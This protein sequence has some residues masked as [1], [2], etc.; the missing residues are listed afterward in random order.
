MEDGV[1]SQLLELNPVEKEK[2]AK[3]FVGWKRK[4]TLYESNEHNGKTLWRL[5]ARSG[6][7]MKEIRF[8]RRDEP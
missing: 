2:R 6:T 3:K 4:P 8:D 1:K 5:W 7:W